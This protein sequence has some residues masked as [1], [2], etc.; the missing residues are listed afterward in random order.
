MTK[1]Y[2]RYCARHDDITYQ[3]I[4]KAFGLN[5]KLHETA[6][7]RMKALSQPHLSQP[8]FSYDVPSPALEAK[9]R[10]IRLPIDE[11]RDESS[12]VLFVNDNLWVPINV[13]NG[14]IHVLP[15]VPRLFT[16]L[17]DGLKPLLIARLTD[18]EGKG[19]YRII[20]STPMAESA[21]AAYLT[22]LAGKVESRGIKVGSYPRWGRKRNSVT[23]VGK[24]KE[25]ME[26]LVSEV[27][28][29]VEGI[30]VEKEEEAG[31]SSDEDHG[32]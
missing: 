27:E 7:Q 5:L 20:I 3:S 8:N 29:N 14:N 21:V 18:P 25:Y 19:I 23:L 4:A 12:Q 13:V 31:E 26:S 17:L 11:S 28:K 1:A 2:S 15:G 6:L 24:D 16:Q 22:E 10:M 32:S 9:L 30:R